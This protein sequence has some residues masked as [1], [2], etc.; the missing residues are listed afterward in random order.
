MRTLSKVCGLLLPSSLPATTHLTPCRVSVPLI[1]LQLRLTVV[2]LKALLLPRHS[3]FHR[4]SWC[5]ARPLPMWLQ[6]Q[7]DFGCN[8]RNRLS[9]INSTLILSV[10]REVQV[11]LLSVDVLFV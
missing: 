11:A 1:S 5:C 7:S 6:E 3:H 9:S 10:Y 4:H 8:V 2:S